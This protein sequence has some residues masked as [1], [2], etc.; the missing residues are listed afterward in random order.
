MNKRVTILFLILFAFFYSGKSQES[1]DSLPLINT[2]RFEVRADLTYWHTM[3]EHLNG[4]LEH[5]P[6]E[7]GFAGRYF[8]LV[9]GGNIS[10]QFSYYVRQ[11]I[12]AN[13]GSVT[14]FDNTDFLW[15]NFKLNKHWDFRV[16]KDALAVGSFEYDA[17]PIDV[18]INTY[19]WD[20]FHCFRLGGSV[21]YTTKDQKSKLIFQVA[22]SPYV[23]Y[24]STFKN[25][26]LSYNLMW[27]GQY[28]P[29]IGMYSVN[30][31][32]R[33][34]TH[35]MFLVGIANKVK[36]EKWDLYLDFIHRS[37]TPDELFKDFSVILCGNYYFNSSINLYAKVAY[38]Q[39]TN[40]NE[41]IGFQETGEYWDC[42][43]VP[44]M[45]YI[46]AG[47]GVEYKPKKCPSFRIHGVIDGNFIQSVS[48]GNNLGIAPGETII[49]P[50][51]RAG[52]TWYIDVMK[53]INKKVKK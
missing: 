52:F 23:Y 40:K 2:L 3:V 1:N 21:Q 33:D 51:V 11:R 12:I 45:K 53:Y 25:S 31:F 34:R 30:L 24:G 15:I 22:S 44:G 4:D 7:F 5:Y 38:E 14:L 29:F 49:K 17:T 46:I 9:F 47:I 10:D 43:M 16:G 18:L 36:F 32:Q 39:N 27:S 48:E 41:I 42:L 8:N 20:A 26:L 13:P 19:Y 37:T 50:S 6:S 28:G 35:Y